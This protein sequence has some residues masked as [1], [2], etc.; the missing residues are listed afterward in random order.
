MP[1]ASVTTTYDFLASGSPFDTLAPFNG[2]W[3][4]TDGDPLAGCLQFIANSGSS[5]FVGGRLLT[6]GGPSALTW[7]NLG[8]PAGKFAVYTTATIRSKQVTSSGLTI[9]RLDLTIDWN[10]GALPTITTLSTILTWGIGW[11]TYS[12]SKSC[13][14]EIRSPSNTKIIL[15]LFLQFA[16]NTPPWSLDY[17]FDTFAITV[18]YDDQWC[19][20][21]TNMSISPSTVTLGVGES[22]NFTTNLGADFTIVEGGDSGTLSNVTSTSVTYNAGN[23]PGTYH[24]RA[25]DSC[26]D[27]SDTTHADA[28]ITVSP[29][30][31]IN[32]EATIARES[33]G[34]D[35]SCND[36]GGATDF[37]LCSPIAAGSYCLEANLADLNGARPGENIRIRVRRV[38]NDP[39]NTSTDPCSLVKASIEYDVT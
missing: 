20:Y 23:T 29:V 33:C 21:C 5:S 8:V 28:T 32:F 6:A 39:L 26:R 27:P 35:E 25:T 17:R 37:T 30:D 4:A 10:G 38:W 15:D 9:P 16:G 36:Y 19:D 24:L 31:C 12:H 1:L 3:L 22:H 18:Y 34:S 11:Q 13:V 2:T 14:E 7:E